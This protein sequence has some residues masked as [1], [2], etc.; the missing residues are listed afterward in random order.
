[1]MKTIFAAAAACLAMLA[2]PAAAQD[3]SGPRV[4][5]LLGVSG[6]DSPFD[7][8]EFTYGGVIGYDYAVS[9]TVS[10]G[11]EGDLASVSMDDEDFGID[12][13]NRQLSA[14]LRGTY[15]LSPR[16][17]LFVS[18]GYT[19]LELEAADV[20]VD[21]DGFRVGGGAEFAIGT[22]LYASTEYRY[23]EY[24]LGDFNAG[25]AGIH[26]ALVGLGLRF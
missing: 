19:N 18:G 17:A 1:M 2:V 5:V 11:V 6:D 13:D 8:S 24:D 25:D 14:A 3:F 20:S 7:D 4:G 22:R 16:T 10:I 26:S 9:P 23:S 12:V 21:F 15:A